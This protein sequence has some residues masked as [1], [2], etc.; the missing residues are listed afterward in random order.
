M[1]KSRAAQIRG[2]RSRP[3][4]LVD[5]GLLYFSKSG[6]VVVNLLILPQLQRLM[7]PEEFGLVALFLTVQALLLV[8]DLGLSLIVGRDVAITKTAS[9][10]ALRT[11]RTAE[12]A[13][14]AA[15]IPILLGALILAA[16]NLLPFDLGS[17]A[18]A[19]LTFWL[20]TLQN[21]GYSALIARRD[22][23]VAAG[24][25]VAGTILRGILS[26]VALLVIAP[27]LEVFLAVQAGFSLLQYV[28]TRIRCGYVLE[29]GISARALRLPGPS[30]ITALL[31]RARSLAVFGIAGAMVLQ[32]D[33]LIISVF[34]GPLTMT[35]Y[36]LAT[37]LCLVPISSLAGP[38]ASYFQPAALRAIASRSEV[39]A[40]RQ[41][42]RMLYALTLVT[43]L[44]TVIL[45][46]LRGPIIELWLVG[47]PNAALVAG[48]T[49]ILL[50]GVCIGAFGFIPYIALLGRGDFSFQA[51]MAA[52][53]TVLTLAMTALM[54][55]QGD[56]T[57]ICWVYAVYH[58]SSTALSWLRWCY[59]DRQ[60]GYRIA[61]QIGTLATV[62]IGGAGVVIGIAAVL[63]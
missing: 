48:Y 42:R 1:M 8:F 27:R 6:A 31:W 37:T 21:I 35:P 28:V 17:T 16:L 62:T 19:M 26:L 33:K 43:I 23:A 55:Y 56:V 59:L 34:N 49:A 63:F 47:S 52:T 41:L 2:Q 53:T 38:V 29:R 10:R 25:L 58:A 3:W 30:A 12:L 11:W 60:D 4:R 44:P 24:T 51:R 40:V 50:P 61:V 14:S 18:L 39:E 20:L 46:L 54:A 36:Y 57:A 22:F 5:L 15:Y 32:G 7:S 45:W 9:G 13:L